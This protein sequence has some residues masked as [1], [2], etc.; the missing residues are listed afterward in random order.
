MGKMHK[1][2]L[3]FLMLAMVVGLF[4]M[5]GC[6]MFRT[7]VRWDIRE[8][9]G[10]GTGWIQGPGSAEYE[11]TWP[12]GRTVKVKIERP[13]VFSVNVPQVMNVD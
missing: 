11:E 12:D 3:I 8:G 9:E 6:G 7:K 1:Y 5:S 2:L 4:A 13:S 10:K